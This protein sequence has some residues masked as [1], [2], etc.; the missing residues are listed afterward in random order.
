MALDDVKLTG[1]PAQLFLPSLNGEQNDPSFPK[2]DLADFTKTLEQMYVA[3]PTIKTRAVPVPRETSLALMNE[4]SGKVI[5]TVGNQHTVVQNH[6]LHSAMERTLSN[7]IPKSWEVILE[8]AVSNEGG[9]TS[10]TYRLTDY[11]AEIRQSNGITTT[12]SMQLHLVNPTTRAVTAFCSFRDAS[13]N[14]NVVF[15]NFKATSPH[16]ESFSTDPL[17]G[18]IEAVMHQAPDYIDRLQ[19]YANT[20]LPVSKFDEVLGAQGFITPTIKEAVLRQYREVETPNRGANVFA[21]LSSL[22]AWATH[23][24]GDFYVRNS[25]NSDNEA[26][27]LFARMEKI[28]RIVGSTA[29]GGLV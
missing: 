29:W 26:E 24:Q 16:L 17:E 13:C 25:A 18:Y 9:F 11:S 23:N 7:L 27:A 4:R 15:T 6:V 1:Q 5:A 14:N 28:M 8:E 2:L 3:H 21:G 19:E 22:A 10:L 20:P 12:L